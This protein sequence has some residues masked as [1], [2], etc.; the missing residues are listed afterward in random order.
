MKHC[1]CFP[2]AAD[3]FLLVAVAAAVVLFVVVAAAVVLFVFVAVA[4]AVVFGAYCGLVAS[5]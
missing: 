1:E 4:A 2:A 3:S 5:E